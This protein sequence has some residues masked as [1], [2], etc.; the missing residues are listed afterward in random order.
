VDFRPIGFAGF[1]VADE[2][3]PFEFPPVP[4][5]VLEMETPEVSD[6]ST[7][8][9]RLDAGDP[10]DDFEIHRVGRAFLLLMASKQYSRGQAGKTTVTPVIPSAARDLFVDE[11]E[12]FLVA[13]LLGMTVARGRHRRSR[14]TENALY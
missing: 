10:T 8:S 7:D 5:A 4:C 12:R 2:C 3:K 9:D 1:L 13:S 11:R 14:D 6:R